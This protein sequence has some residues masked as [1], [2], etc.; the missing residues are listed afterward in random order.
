ML[1]KFT[2]D[3]PLTISLLGVAALTLLVRRR[4][5]ARLDR[6]WSDRVGNGKPLALNVSSAA[7]PTS[8]F[9]ETLVGAA[10]PRL[11]GSEWLMTLTAPLLS[12]LAGHALKRLVPRRRP[13]WAGL[14]ENG[15]QS[16]PST[17]SAH[18]AALAYTVAKMAREHGA[19]AW[20]D[21][22]ATAV[23]AVMAFERLRARAHWPTDVLAGA[24]VGLASARVA[25][26]L[27]SPRSS[28]YF[29]R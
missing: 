2:R 19:G 18:A 29:A 22:A 16:F 15:K 10:L 25:G 1:G 9:V 7:K 26:A 12:G 13:G 28:P 5:T 6:R 11:R 4:R 8:G 20:T 27:T 14:G 21:V 17:H 3:P 23:V 24:L